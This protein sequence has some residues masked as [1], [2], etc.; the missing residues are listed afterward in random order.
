M[1]VYVFGNKDSESDNKAFAVAKKLKKPFPK[2]ELVEIEP[3]ADLPFKPNEH[4]YI[5]DAV[6]GISE[7][8]LIENDDLDKL[9]NKNSTSVHDFDLGFQLKY[10]K[11]LNKLGNVTIIGI[12]M[13]GP[14]DYLRIQSIFKKLVAQD[15]QGS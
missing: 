2:L 5:L 15:M 4:V 6:E 11:K 1:K 8:T 12:P 9:V 14:I 10:L 3:N 13:K 7:P